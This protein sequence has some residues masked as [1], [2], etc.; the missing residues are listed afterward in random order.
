MK[1]TNILC[2]SLCIYDSQVPATEKGG[3]GSFIVAKSKHN[4]LWFLI[5]PEIP[6]L[7]FDPIYSASQNQTTYSTH[8]D[9][10]MLY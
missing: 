9:R 10:I 3:V 8:T 2:K 1:V 4:M 6:H 5:I 7:V